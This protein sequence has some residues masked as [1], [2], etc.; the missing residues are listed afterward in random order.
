[1]EAASLG[2]SIQGVGAS[3]VVPKETSAEASTTSTE[4]S[5]TT[6]EVMEASMDVVNLHG[7]MEVFMEA[8]VYLRQKTN[9]EDRPAPGL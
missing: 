2:T 1:M 6:M 7:S 8:S 9:V 5:T 4:A 3:S